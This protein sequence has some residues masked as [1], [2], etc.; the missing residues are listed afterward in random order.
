MSQRIQCSNGLFIESTHYVS[1]PQDGLMTK[2]EWDK[3]MSE[4]R[5]KTASMK[6]LAEELVDQVLAAAHYES[7]GNSRMRIHCRGE[8]I[9]VLSEILSRRVSITTNLFAKE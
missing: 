7:Q 9:G 1:C 6:A 2:E 4:D 8:A 3:K 5:I